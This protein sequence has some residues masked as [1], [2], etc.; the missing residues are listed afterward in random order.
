MK[1]NW[2]VRLRNPHFLLQIGL[3]ILAPIL[4]YNQVS[5]EDVTTWG[6]LIALLISAI[7][8]PYVLCLVGISVYNAISDPTTAGISDSARALKYERPGV[9]KYDYY[10]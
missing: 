10:K 9:L 2:K 1:I 3:S 4:A 8:N 7:K 6:A 5:G